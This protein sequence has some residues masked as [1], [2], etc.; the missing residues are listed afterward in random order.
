MATVTEPS[1]DSITQLGL[2]VS[3][4]TDSEALIVDGQAVALTD[5]NSATTQADSDQVSVAVS[6]GTATV[7][8]TN[9]SNFTNAAAQTLVDG[10][11]Y[12]D[13]S[14]PLTPGTRTVTLTQLQDNESAGGPTSTALSIASTVTVDAKPTVTSAT[15]S[16]LAGNDIDAGKTVISRWR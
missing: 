11:A 4:V 2:T 14:S 6:G 13:Q 7:T 15:F 9:P 3:N 12:E 16:S 5:G 8:I 1:R 10:V